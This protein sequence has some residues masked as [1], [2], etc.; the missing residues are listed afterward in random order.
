MATNLAGGVCIGELQACIVRAAL[1]DT[2]C[3]PTGG[4]NGGIVTAGLVTMTADPEIDAGTVYEQKSACGDILFT[5]EK[6]D[7]IKR[8]NVSGEFGFADF[9]MMAL[10]FGGTTILG[11][12]AGLYNGKVIGYA[13]R[14]YTASSRTGVYLEVITTAIV[15]GSGGCQYTGAATGTAP[16]AI[17]HI[18]GKA[19]LVPGSMNFADDIKRVTFSGK[20]ANNPN[21][22]NGPWNDYPGAGYTPNSPH[23]AV[24]YS[25]AEYNAIAAQVNCGYRDI[26]VGS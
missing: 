10:L 11:R 7:V 12:A 17:G 24:G 4:V 19:K 9:E 3:T 22:T 18:F 21:L 13:D 15:E 1:L 25:E 5:Y 23:V 14:L 20:A 6:D 8:Y 26:P 16:F 2:D